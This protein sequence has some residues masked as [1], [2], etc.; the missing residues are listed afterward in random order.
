MQ[1]FG[2]KKPDGII[3][4]LAES[5]HNSWKAFF[6]QP[7]NRQEIMPHRLPV[8]EAI[9]AYEAIGYKCIELEVREKSV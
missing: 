4:W 7:S 3:W 9:R 5:E 2:I 1:Y 6:S 8:A